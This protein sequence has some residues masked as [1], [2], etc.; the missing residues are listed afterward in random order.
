MDIMFILETL[1]RYVGDTYI[2]WLFAAAIIGAI[3]LR[4]ELFYKVA[5]PMGLF[6]TLTVYNPLLS[7]WVASSFGVTVEYYRFFWILPIVPVIAVMAINGM[8]KLKKT[9]FQVP[10][11]VLVLVIVSL[12][13]GS[14]I[15]R[16]SFKPAETIYKLPVTLTQICHVAHSYMP[17][18]EVT[19]LADAS[20]AIALRQYDA[21]IKNPYVRAELYTMPMEEMPEDTRTMA[22]VIYHQTQES[23]I[24]LFKET[25]KARNIDFIV[26]TTN[27]QTEGFLTSA[28]LQCIDYIGPYSMFWAEGAV[29]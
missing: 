28:G 18:Q 16:Q 17:E 14:V 10:Y 26:V 12:C 7:A 24:G 11:V 27:E 4:L 8:D 6:L 22:Q 2:L 1:M 23:D 19:I 3:V 9:I 5:I 21:S 25:I 15:H 13:G 29:Y 20:V